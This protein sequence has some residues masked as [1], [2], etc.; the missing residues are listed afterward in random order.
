MISLL[1]TSDIKVK[2]KELVNTFYFLI[3][4]LTN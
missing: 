1:L 3:D 2:C 4:T